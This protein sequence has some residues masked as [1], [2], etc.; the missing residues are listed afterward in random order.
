MWTIVCRQFIFRECETRHSHRRILSIKSYICPLPKSCAMK[1]PLL[2]A[3]ICWPVVCLLNLSA[4]SAH[5]PNAASPAAKPA[6]KPTFTASPPQEATPE[7]TPK[8]WG[9]SRCTSYF[10]SVVDSFPTDSAYAPNL[11]AGAL[12]E[13]VRPTEGRQAVELLT[14]ADFDVHVFN[15]NTDLCV[16][17]IDE[18][19]IA[20][21]GGKGNVPMA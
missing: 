21:I 18:N 16:Q 7:F 12:P 1:K 4:S 14:V 19:G 6:T 20:N 9:M 10:H 8:G 17:V 15:N 13:N 3:A 2:M 11:A 5:S